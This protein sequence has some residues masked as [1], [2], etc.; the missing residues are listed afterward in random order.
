[1]KTHTPQ[2]IT[3]RLLTL[4]FAVLLCTGCHHLGL[5][6]VDRPLL[7]PSESKPSV[8]PLGAG[9]CET[10]WAPLMTIDNVIHSE[11]ILESPPEIVI[12]KADIIESSP[13]SDGRFSG[14]PRRPYPPLDSPE[15]DSIQPAK[16]V[17]EQRGVPAQ[18]AAKIERNFS[19]ALQHNEQTT[20]EQPR[21][22][23]GHPD[24]YV[25]RAPSM[26]LSQMIHANR[27]P[28]Q[29]VSHHQSSGRGNSVV[30]SAGDV[31]TILELLHSEQIP[32]E[33]V[34]RGR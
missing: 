17:Q 30:Q 24:V 9:Y 13:V 3:W 14:H 26:T 12:P 33:T 5:Q 31:E 22:L 11:I 19:Q 34:N 32:S 21:L 15:R 8:M 18:V 16:A 25:S 6:P 27:Q 29:R 2:R 1:M 23:R 10:N 7:K 20:L 28:V 4:S